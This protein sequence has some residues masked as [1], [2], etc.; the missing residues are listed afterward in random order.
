MSAAG[1]TRKSPLR[2]LRKLTRQ[3]RRSIAVHLG[4]AVPVPANRGYMI[5][6]SARSGSTYFCRLLA[7]TGLLGHPREY[8]N[9][10]AR[11]QQDPD[12]P[13]DPREQLGLV[14]SAGATKNGI[15]GLKVFPNHIQLLEPK[16]DLFRD[17]PNLALV[18]LVRRDLLGQAISLARAR[19]VWK[20][21]G[22]AL[23]PEQP[24]YDQQQITECIGHI[25]GD[26]RLWSDILARRG[27]Q[28]L[29]VTYEEISA[30]PQ[31]VVDR[32]AALLGLPLPVPIGPGAVT[33][34]V[35][36]DAISAEWRQRFLAE[37][38]EEFGHL[39]AIA[40]PRST[41]GSASAS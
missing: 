25:I 15:Y 35:Q 23:Q 5:C 4:S 41:P 9:L 1:T 7:S 26:G 38:G 21:N 10:R 37:T 13:A 20:R 6:G 24:V 8:F 33:S 19:Q 27:L 36:R 3:W 11:R 34:K 2:N 18:Q 17:L 32:V 31:P 39:A 12:Y 40:T 28:P 22:A 16:I 14:F 30:D 29:T